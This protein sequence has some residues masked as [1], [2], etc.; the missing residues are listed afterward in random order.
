MV[1]YLKFKLNDLHIY[2]YTTTYVQNGK[3][4]PQRKKAKDDALQDKKLE[5]GLKLFNENLRKIKIF[6]RKTGNMLND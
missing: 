2:T 1:L 4:G 5:N 3:C 6:H